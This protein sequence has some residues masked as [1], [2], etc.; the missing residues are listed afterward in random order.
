[1][2]QPEE[3]VVDLIQQSQES[4]K[5]AT[6]PRQPEKQVET[7]TQLED[8]SKKQL[9][10][11]VKETQPTPELILNIVIYIYTRIHFTFYNRSQ[12]FRLE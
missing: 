12:S 10:N 3:Q 2:E 5:H 6:N 8:D 4:E 9:E 1:M 7:S 11:L